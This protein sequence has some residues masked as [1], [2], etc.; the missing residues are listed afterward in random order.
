MQYVQLNVAAAL[1][2]YFLLYLCFF[3]IGT[4]QKQ[5][6]HKINTLRQTLLPRVVY[7]FYG[8]FTGNYTVFSII[9]IN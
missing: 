5:R 8:K 4:I 6:R 7:R 3:V 9:T 2:F 1:Q